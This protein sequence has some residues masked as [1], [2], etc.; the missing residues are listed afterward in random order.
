MKENFIKF[1]TFN[2]QFYVREGTNDRGIISNVSGYGKSFQGTVVV[3]G[4]HIGGF[5]CFAARNGAEK[6]YCY[7]PCKDNFD[8]LVKNIK[9][10]NLED[11]VFPRKIALSSEKDS[12]KLYLPAIHINSGML[13]FYYGSGDRKFEI[14]QC[15]TLENI[16]KDENIA[17]CNF[18]KSD[19]EGGEYDIF[20]NA[21][22]DI[23][24]KINQI[25]MEAHFM[26]PYKLLV[27][28]FEKKG[29]EV[30]TSTNRVPT[31]AMMLFANNMKFKNHEQ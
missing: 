26:K 18:I 17:Y 3:I 4:A 12:R 19:C 13:G 10:N 6:V 27:E 23:L 2:L 15:D 29:F 24:S 31:G 16:F 9:L 25:V 1:T 11:K 14:V 8:L 28:F 30:T 22:D 21:S 7:E 5:S 20:L